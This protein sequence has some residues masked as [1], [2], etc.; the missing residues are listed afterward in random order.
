MKS[1]KT[2]EW[3]TVV[4]Y[5]EPHHRMLERDGKPLSA[6]DQRK[7]QEK[8]DQ[9]V[10]K[11]EQE[12]PEQ[13]ARRQADYEKKREKDREF[14]REVPDLFDFKLLGDEKIDGH[15]VW[16]IS[17]TPKTGRAAEARRRETV[18][19]GPGQG[20]DRQG[21]VSMGAAGSGDHG[22]HFVRAVHRAA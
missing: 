7:E 6:P 2:E 10:A 19:E 18:A 11:R 20:L 17:A 13:R 3:E 16:V 15:D 8:L 14:L 1:E 22:D 9:A 12:T 4:I 5:G 21:R